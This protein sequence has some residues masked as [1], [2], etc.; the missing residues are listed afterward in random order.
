MMLLTFVG[1]FK[2]DLVTKLCA[3]SD[4]LRAFQVGA[5]EPIPPGAYTLPLETRNPAEPTTNRG[6][7]DTPCGYHAPPL[8][9]LIPCYWYFYA[10]V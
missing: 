6:G 2:D 10:F 5:D 3:R 4:A 9:V 1:A 8:T 7:Q